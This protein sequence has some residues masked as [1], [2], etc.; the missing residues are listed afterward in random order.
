MRTILTIPFL[1]FIP[2]CL[3]ANSFTGTVVRVADGDTCVVQKADSSKFQVQ[4]SK[5]ARKEEVRIRL[6][7]IDAPEKSQEHGKESADALAR[8]ILGRTVVVE[9]RPTSR[10][11]SKALRKDRYGRII[12]TVYLDNRN[13]NQDMVRDGFAWW[14]RKYS[15]DNN[16]S[17]LETNARQQNRG[18]WTAENPT[19]PW[20][21][22]KRTRQFLFS[23]FG[24]KTLN[25]PT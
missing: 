9:Y 4:G 22:R 20:H 10:N 12:G 2:L 24:H 1:C 16:L 15:K 5:S 6:V 14:Y 19:A 21:Y 3:Y 13:I 11:T 18:L 8:K 23:R 17:E 25:G 7:G